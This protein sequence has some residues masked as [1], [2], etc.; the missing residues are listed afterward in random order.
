[1]D[2]KLDDL[3]IPQQQ[4]QNFIS[5]SEIARELV[6]DLHSRSGYYYPGTPVLIVGA[7]YLGYVEADI[8][9]LRFP[10]CD[11]WHL[12]FAAREYGYLVAHNRTPRRF[13]LLWE[14]IQQ[15]IDPKK[16]LN[17][18]PPE[19]KDC[20]LNEIID[21]W[22]EYHSLRTDD[23]RSDFNRENELRLN[24]LKNQQ[25]NH[26]CHLFA[27]AFATAFVGPAYIHALLNLRFNPNS[28]LYDSLEMPSLATRFVFAL[29]TLKWM[30]QEFGDQYRG[31]FAGEV[32]EDKNISD[33]ST[34]LRGLWNQTIN[35]AEAILSKSMLNWK[36]SKTWEELLEQNEN[37]D[38]KPIDP[39]KYDYDYDEILDKYKPWLKEILAT[40][41]DVFF[42]GISDKEGDTFKNWEEAKKLEK[43]INNSDLSVEQRPNIWVV[44]NAAW[45]ARWR[46]WEDLDIIERN[47][48][49]LIDKNDTSVLTDKTEDIPK[50][51]TVG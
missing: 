9:H 27:D 32:F 12:P 46:H 6:S 2:N 43:N 19:N 26:L 13:E 50:I 30:N 5:F 35:S 23:E 48:L 20:F 3:R 17:D 18:S 14:E 36:L 7:E 34:G 49:R 37:K 25:K 4:Q 11:F 33:S 1:M 10:A 8:I 47:A 44:V 15:V 24:E 39:K 40:F 31:T 16:H 29:E 45:S 28:S 41:M 21:L 38:L 42:R 51:P 22:N